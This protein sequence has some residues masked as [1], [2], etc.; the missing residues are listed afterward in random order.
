MGAKR[1]TA[2]QS[3]R[4]AAALR[5]GFINILNALRTVRGAI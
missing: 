1:C 2:A 5:E 4:L 3:S